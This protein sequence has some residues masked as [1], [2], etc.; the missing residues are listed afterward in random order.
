MKTR[1]HSI[2]KESGIWL[3]ANSEDQ[4]P[5]TIQFSSHLTT[6][7]TSLGR[8]LNRERVETFGIYEI[9]HGDL[10]G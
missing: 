3:R 1:N 4:R 10:H 8:Q 9:R 5:A 2:R 6:C 7:T